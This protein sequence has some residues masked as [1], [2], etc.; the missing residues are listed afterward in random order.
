MKEFDPNKIY[1]LYD[2]NIEHKA[3][4]DP[5]IKHRGVFLSTTFSSIAY[6]TDII[7]API[8]DLKNHVSTFNFLLT[9]SYNPTS[10]SEIISAILNSYLVEVDKQVTKPDEY[11]TIIRY[12]V[13][14]S[15]SFETIE[16][17]KDYNPSLWRRITLN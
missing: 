3:L 4:H 13:I 10:N 9:R 16:V 5:N 11:R 7:E 1:V 6:V 12:D 15:N 2:P 14:Y 8:V 17:L